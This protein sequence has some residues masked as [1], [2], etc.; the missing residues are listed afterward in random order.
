MIFI[1]IDLEHIMHTTYKHFILNEHLCIV[2]SG[3]GSEPG[4]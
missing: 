3:S 1:Q 2:A 4:Y